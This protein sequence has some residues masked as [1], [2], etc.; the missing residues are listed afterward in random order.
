MKKLLI[1]GISLFSCLVVDVAYPTNAL[2]ASLRRSCKYKGAEYGTHITMENTVARYD[3]GVK[4]TYCVM[5]GLTSS[6]KIDCIGKVVSILQNNGS[7]SNPKPFGR[8]SI[9]QRS[10]DQYYF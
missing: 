2:G 1:T 9:A 4:I 6:Q 10:C 7:Y 8:T 3:R 5:G